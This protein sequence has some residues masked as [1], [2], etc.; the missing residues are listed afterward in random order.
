MTLYE[1]NLLL[2]FFFFL[3]GHYWGHFTQNRLFEGLV[4]LLEMF[5]AIFN[6]VIA[7]VMFIWPGLIKRNIRLNK[8]HKLQ[9]SI[10]DS[11]RA[12]L[13]GS[14]HNNPSLSHTEPLI[15]C[16][17]QTEGFNSSH[18]FLLL[19]RVTAEKR[20]HTNIWLTFVCLSLN[21]TNKIKYIANF[22]TLALLIAFTAAE[23]LHNFCMTV[24]F[25]KMQ[26]SKLP[27]EVL[28]YPFE[29]YCFTVFLFLNVV[30]SLYILQP[31]L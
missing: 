25:L 21:I 11:T 5:W 20:L 28:V 29:K 31:A 2:F 7:C 6:L 9:Q 4:G 24:T 16:S 17:L 30:V 8:S 26:Y 22:N 1:L 3:N 13:H 23:R 18:L 12:A 15:G 19:I 14:A 10:A 27:L